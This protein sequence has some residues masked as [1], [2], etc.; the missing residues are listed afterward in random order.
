MNQWYIPKHALNHFWHGVFIFQEIEFTEDE[1]EGM[2]DWL[3][4]VMNGGR[5]YILM[6]HISINAQGRVP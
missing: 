4:K 6:Y 1:I 5:L 2:L 3:M